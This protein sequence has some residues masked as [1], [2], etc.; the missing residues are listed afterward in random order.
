V[1]ELRLREKGDL[2][3]LLAGPG[4][5]ESTSPYSRGIAGSAAHDLHTKDVPIKF[6][7]VGWVLDVEADVMNTH[8]ATTILLPLAHISE[9]SG[10]VFLLFFLFV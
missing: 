7:T 10:G 6:G 1:L 3:A 9:K 4:G 2:V 5:Q 8:I